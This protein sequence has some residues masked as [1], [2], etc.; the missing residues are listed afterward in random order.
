MVDQMKH[1]HSS[2]E[3]GSD[4]PKEQCQREGISYYF[5]LK[6]LKNYDRANEFVAPALS[7]APAKIV[8]FFENRTGSNIYF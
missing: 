7:H 8:R 2:H 6:H 4:L 5:L 3:R 1:C